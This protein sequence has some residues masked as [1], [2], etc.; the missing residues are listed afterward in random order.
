MTTCPQCGFADVQ[1]IG[2]SYYECLH[3]HVG[4]FPDPMSGRPVPYSRRCGHAFQV[5]ADSPAPLLPLCLCRVFFAVGSCEDCQ[6]PVCNQHSEV[7]DE[8]FRCADCAAR[9]DSRTAYELVLPFCQAVGVLVD[10]PDPV[11]R[12]VRWHA[13]LRID[14]HLKASDRLTCLFPVL[15]PDDARAGRS[16]PAL[17]TATIAGWFIDRA[18]AANVL[19]VACY[20]YT[21]KRLRG[22]R[23]QRTPLIAWPFPR[24][25]SSYEPQR[26][27]AE[28]AYVFEDG[29]VLLPFHYQKGFRPAEL[30]HDALSQMAELLNLPD[31][32]L[33][34]REPWATLAP[35]H[36][37]NPWGNGH[38]HTFKPAGY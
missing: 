13:L 14:G 8:R 16:L 30:S 11:E 38:V 28:D 7:Q 35:R 12:L 27:I 2:P 22:G 17:N 37:H 33:I 15:F 6:R 25:S 34:T 20:Q 31:L 36:A 10:T 5:P 3:V 32:P 26:Y 21:T 18:R 23:K 29:R 19:P 24:G 1:L 4:V 9:F